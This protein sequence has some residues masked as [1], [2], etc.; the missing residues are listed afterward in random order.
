VVE[1]GSGGDLGLR[2][3]FEGEKWVW[4]K[5]WADCMQQVAWETKTGLDRPLFFVGTKF[6]TFQRVNIYTV[7]YY[8]NL[9]NNKSVS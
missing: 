7:N 2:I 3:G 6:E 8:K 1:R 5:F 9:K 4:W